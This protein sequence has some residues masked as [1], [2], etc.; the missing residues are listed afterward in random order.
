LHPAPAH[1]KSLI[2]NDIPHRYAT[3]GRERGSHR[4]KT[5]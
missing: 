2:A 1:H 3:E 4:Q 5:C